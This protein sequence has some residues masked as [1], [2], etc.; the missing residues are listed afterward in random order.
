MT[1][2]DATQATLNSLYI[3]LWQETSFTMIDYTQH[4]PSGDF[5]NELVTYS[6]DADFMQVVNG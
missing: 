3:E 4:Q 1:Y 6:F 2:T 5:C